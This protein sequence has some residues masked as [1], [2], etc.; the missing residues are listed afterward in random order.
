MAPLWRVGESLEESDRSVGRHLF[1]PNLLHLLNFF[2]PTCLEKQIK[3]ASSE[4][5]RPVE[6][7]MLTEFPK[8]QHQ[9]ISIFCNGL[10]VLPGPVVVLSQSEETCKELKTQW[11]T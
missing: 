10:P 3:S 11:E 8:M 2:H 6:T 7:Y 9:M 1:V 5:S 4:L